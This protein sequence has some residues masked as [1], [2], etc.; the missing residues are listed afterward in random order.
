M[1]VV[2]CGAAVL[3]RTSDK[4]LYY[5]LLFGAGSIIINA[6]FL[7]TMQAANFGENYGR[8]S[9]FYLN[10]NLAGGICI[11]GFSLSY[12]IKNTKWKLFGQIICTLAGIFTFSRTFIVIWLI[13]NLISIYN[14]KKNAIAPVIGV[15]AL[16]FVFAFSGR[17]TLNKERFEALKSVVGQG[18]GNTQVIGEDSR[19]ATWANYYDLIYAKPFVGHGFRKFQMKGGGLP[20]VHNSYLMVIG[21]AGIIPFLL[22][23]GIYAYLLRKSYMYFKSH[24]WYFYIICATILGM[25]GGHGYFSNFPTVF[26]SMYVF[27]KLKDL[28]SQQS[29]EIATHNTIQ[30]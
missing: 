24:P 25:M 29:E 20:G 11:L 23:I 5:I 1:I 27:I 6:V 15:L 30:T 8:F 7:P 21:E 2:V 14:N 22:F 19:S 18:R 10:P 13:I 9:G 28:S 26:I 3:Y 4:E 17:L 12:A 16:V